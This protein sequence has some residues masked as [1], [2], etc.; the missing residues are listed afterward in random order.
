MPQA[1]LTVEYVPKARQQDFLACGDTADPATVCGGY[2]LT[3]VNSIAT[4][5][6][7]APPCTCTVKS[8]ADPSTFSQVCDNPCP[9]ILLP[10]ADCDPE[11]I[12]KAAT[13]SQTPVCVP[14]P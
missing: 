4:A 5:C 1:S 9:A 7:L 11:A 14:A 8:G 13:A 3:S 6:Q 2:V 12:V 10:T